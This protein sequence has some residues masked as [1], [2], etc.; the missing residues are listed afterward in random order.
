MPHYTISGGTMIALAADEIVMDDNAVIGPVDRQL[1]Q[2]PAVSIPSV[3]EKKDIDEIDDQTLTQADI[4]RKAIAQ[5]QA[6]LRCILSARKKMLEDQ[7]ETLAKKLSSGQ[8]THDYPVTVDEGRELGLS[9]S[10][11][12]PM[13]VYNL[14]SLYPRAPECRPSVECV[15]TLYVIRPPRGRGMESRLL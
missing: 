7:A 4:A 5:I 10:I 15:S 3:L 11:K 13:E 6:T 14:M 2:M 8:W 1:G 9:V 12:M